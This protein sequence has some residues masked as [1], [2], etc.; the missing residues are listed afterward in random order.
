MDCFETDCI[1]QFGKLVMQIISQTD[2]V[3]H[4][5]LPHF[6]VV[7]SVAKAAEKY[8]RNFAEK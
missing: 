3:V 8:I 2:S 7:T 1:T 4:K 6:R 5:L